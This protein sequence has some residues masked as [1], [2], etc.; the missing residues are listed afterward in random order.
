M[1]PGGK[2]LQAVFRAKHQAMVRG[3]L[4]PLGPAERRTFLNLMAKIALRAKP[5]VEAEEQMIR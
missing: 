4:A 3:W 5:E 2:K 1:S